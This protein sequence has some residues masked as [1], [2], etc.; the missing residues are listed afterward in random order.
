MNWLLFVLLLFSTVGFL[1]CSVMLFF[2]S[3]GSILK[4]KKKKSFSVVEVKLQRLN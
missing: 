4:K 2:F 1:H 3:F